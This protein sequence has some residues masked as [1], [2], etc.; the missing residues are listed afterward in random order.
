MAHAVVHQRAAWPPLAA[1]PKAAYPRLLEIKYPDLEQAPALVEA[2]TLTRALLPAQARAGGMRQLVKM[3]T[4]GPMAM[5]AVR[6]EMKLAAWMMA[7]ERLLG[8]VVIS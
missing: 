3:M 5:T 1:Y 6:V 2:H 7:I 4:A 8:E